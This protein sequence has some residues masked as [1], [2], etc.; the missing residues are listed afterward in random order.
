MAD[1][2]NGRVFC[3]D[4]HLTTTTP[5]PRFGPDQDLDPGNYVVEGKDTLN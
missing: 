4:C 5:S 1:D 3:F 2:T